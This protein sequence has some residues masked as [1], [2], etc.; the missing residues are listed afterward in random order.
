MDETGHAERHR[1]RMR[2]KKQ[3]V[4][5][6]IAAAQSD[7][8]VPLVHTGEGKSSAALGMVGRA[9]GHGMHAAVVRFI[10]GSR[11]AGEAAFFRRFPEVSGHVMGEGFTWETQDRERIVWAVGAACAQARS[12]L[13]DP[14]F[15][16]V[17]PGELRIA[18]EYGYVSFGEALGFLR[19]GPRSQHGVV[20]GRGAPAALIELADTV[21]D[22]RDIRHAFRPGVRAQKGIEL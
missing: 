6:S 5:A 16:L 22:M 9:F 19:S 2:P 7:R 12:L 4:D 18:L 21:S 10:K 1:V 3:I 20:T 13:A 11:R 8:G 14:R 17:L 15:E